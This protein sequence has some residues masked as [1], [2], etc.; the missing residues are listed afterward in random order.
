MTRSP[1]IGPSPA[2]PDAE[3]PPAVVPQ[4]VSTR[5]AATMPTVSFRTEALRICFLLW[6]SGGEPPLD[7]EGGKCRGPCHACVRSELCGRCVHG[8]HRLGFVLDCC[9][10]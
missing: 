7:R 3:P 4:P 10:S 5:P 9:R 6:M 2:L 1:L 8:R